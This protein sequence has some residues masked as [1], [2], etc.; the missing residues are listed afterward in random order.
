MNIDVKACWGKSCMK[1]NIQLIQ[2]SKF[3][4]FIVVGRKH[5]VMGNEVE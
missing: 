5:E 4:C 2:L 3:N 1:Y